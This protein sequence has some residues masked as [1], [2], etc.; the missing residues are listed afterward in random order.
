M[1]DVGDGQRGVLHEGLRRLQPVFRHHPGSSAQAPVPGSDPV[2]TRPGPRRSETPVAPI[3]V[4][5]SICC[6]ERD[7]LDA[8]RI[9]RIDEA[10]Q[11]VEVAAKVV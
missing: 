5:V 8:L 9:Q 6:R 2:H 1:A 7:K 4:V 3:V 11:I 10:Q